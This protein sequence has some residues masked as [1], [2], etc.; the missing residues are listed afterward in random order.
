MPAKSLKDWCAWLE[1]L[2]PNEIEL[3]LE[4]VSAV[5]E[6]LNLLS[7]KPRVITVAG[8]N[9]KGSTIAAI[10]SIFLALGAKIGTYTSPHIY[11]YNERIR[12]NGRECVDEEIVEAFELVEVARSAIPLTYFEY[13]TLAALI[14]FSKQDLDY[15]LLEV[16]LGGRLDAVNIVTADIAVITSIS[17][18][19]TDWLGSDREQIA[20]EKAGILRPGKLFICAD[21]NPP[22]TLKNI[23]KELECQSYWQGQDFSWQEND[24]VWSW[25][26]LNLQGLSIEIQNLPLG[27]LMPDNLSAAIQTV[28]LAE[29]VPRTATLQRVFA[30]LKLTGRQQRCKLQNIEYILD[31]SH[32]LAAVEA[33]NKTLV[34]NPVSGRT[35]AV[36][37]AMSGKDIHGMI[38]AVASS[39]EAWFVADLP[40]VAKAAKGSELAAVLQDCG[41]QMI[42]V[43]KNPKQALRRAQSLMGP[44]DRLVVFGSFHTISEV[45]PAL[46]KDSKRALSE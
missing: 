7:V 33:L 4:R 24:Q 13:T 2:N 32:N 41:V 15:L 19:H 26:G 23:S 12:I 16:G 1:T 22:K 8:T 31:V 43:N 27:Q 5:A 44:G 37:S 25:Q 10:E 21:N 18:D 45:K 3:G 38:K 30:D 36:F 35:G 20:T 6:S 17:I 11:Q 14:I 29:K 40:K 34:E 42:S 39:I 46:D 9:G 28:C